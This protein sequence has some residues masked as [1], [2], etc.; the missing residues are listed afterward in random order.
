MFMKDLL[1]FE[2]R[3]FEF[4]ILFQEILEAFGLMD[5]L[6]MDTVD[7]NFHEKTIKFHW[8]EM[9]K[10]YKLTEQ[11]IVSCMGEMKDLK[12]TG[13]Q[14]KES[15]LGLKP[16]QD[17]RSLTEKQKQALIQHLVGLLDKILR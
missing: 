5:T 14:I 13:C 3:Y 11:K 7:P 9:G 10:P 16:N 12:E 4:D 15:V 1:D 6:T 2:D 8:R 17:I